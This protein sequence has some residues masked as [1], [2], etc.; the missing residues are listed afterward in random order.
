MNQ[1]RQIFA[2]LFVLLLIGCLTSAIATK[3][4]ASPSLRGAWQEEG[5]RRLL[6][7]EPDRVIEFNGQLTV[8]GIVRR[9]HGQL[10][11]RKLGF[12][13]AWD[14]YLRGEELHIGEGTESVVFR[15]LADI[16]PEVDLKPLP[17]GRSRPL[18]KKK[19]EEIQIEI[20]DRFHEEQAVYKN[21]QRNP[22]MLEA[23]KVRNLE[24]LATLVKDIGW[25]DAARFGRQTSVYT[26]ILAKHTN[27]LRLMM[28]IL[29]RAEKDLKYSGEGQT[30]AVLYDGLQIELG[31]KQRYGTQIAED[32]KGEP[33]V[34]PLESPDKVDSY[35]KE[36][37]LPPLDSYLADVC[38]YFYPGKKIRLAQESQMV[39]SY[40]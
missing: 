29:P 20:A 25:V 4:V 23:L 24:Y 40:R 28:A 11:L 16:P 8:R 9:E 34:L 17:L 15:R 38:N 36:M 26:V 3:A 18:S 6:N 35:L 32:A 13:E 31:G 12:L 33:I 27:D 22:Q 1:S 37:G 39:A 14:L 5:G 10:L 21:P 2:S 19:L 30:Y 7:F